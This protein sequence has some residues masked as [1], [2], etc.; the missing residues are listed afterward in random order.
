MEKERKY[1][2]AKVLSCQPEKPG[3]AAFLVRL[4]MQESF[5]AEVGQFVS[6]KSLAGFCFPRPITLADVEGNTI[7]LLI[8]MRGPNTTAY[9][10]LAPGQ[11][12]MV[13]GPQG[14]PL[15]DLSERNLIFVG[16]GIGVSPL[17]WPIKKAARE[18]KFIRVALGGRDSSHLYA[19]D[20]FR[21]LDLPVS[22]I[23]DNGDSGRKG[24]VTE[25][26]EEML[27]EGEKSVTV[28]ACGPRLMLRKVHDIC[29][30]YGVRCIVIIEELMACNRGACK[31]CAIQLLEEKDGEKQFR[32]VCSDGPGFVSSEI[33]WEIIAPWPTVQAEDRPR[34]I[35]EE[36]SMSA[37]IGPVKL[38]SPFIGASGCF[39]PEDRFRV[40]ISRLG[41]VVAKGPT[42]TDRPGNKSPRICEVRAGMINSIG[43]A[44]SGIEQFLAKKLPL[45]FQWGIP[46]FANISGT[47]LEEYVFLAERLDGTGIAGIEINVSCPN[48]RVGGMVFGTDPHMTGLVVNAVRRATSLPLITKLTPNVTK[49][50]EVARAA[51]D[52]GADIISCVNTF[53][54]MSINPWTRRPRIGAGFGGLSGP[55]ILEQA[56]FKTFE[57]LGAVKIPVMGVGGIASGAD[58]AQFVQIGAR[59]IQIGTASFN[60]PDVFTESY[61]ELADIII[62]NGFFT[63]EEM[64]GTVIW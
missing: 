2:K 12:I 32:Y 34:I 28:I 53:V 29:S 41:A 5:L 38:R 46:V 31:G 7:A 15:P 58:A 36:I 60:N 26:L 17:T 43:L 30:R 48:V 22:T 62:S 4:R 33:D 20:F 6:L 61:N 55:A 59:A 9:S 47:T 11:T 16:G 54:A 44:K 24:Y 50:G 10:Q 8:E 56:L 49:I 52:A 51:E 39:E 13:M 63:F 25:L 35:R 21:R 57:V 45:W 18:K 3:S 27:A 23:T 14:S 1:F 37:A 42:L 40:D 19:L 64:I